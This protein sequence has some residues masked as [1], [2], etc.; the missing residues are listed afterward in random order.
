MAT[1]RDI[2]PCVLQMLREDWERAPHGQKGNVVK[3]WAKRTGLGYQALYKT[4]PCQRPQK[5]KSERKIEGIETAARIVAQYK[6]MAPDQRRQKVTEDAIALAVKNG[7]IEARFLDVSIGTF[8]RVIRELGLVPK[9]ARKSHFQADRPNQLHHIDA[10]SCDGFYIAAK[11]PDGDYLLKLYK[12]NYGDYKNKPTP[13]GLRPWYYGYVDDYSGCW[14]ARMVAALGESAGDNIDFLC[15]AWS[16]ES[17]MPWFGTPERLMGDKGPMIRDKS[18]REF[19]QRAADIVPEKGMPGNSAAHGK[20]EKVWDITWSRVT[21]PYFTGDWQ[22]FSITMSEFNRRY[23]I[24]QREWSSKR[25]HR[26]E[27]KVT[28]QQM[29]ERINLHGGAVV[30]PE[31]ALKTVVRC[32]TRNVDQCGCVSIDGI[33]Y[34]IKGL[35]S[36]KVKLYRGRFDDKLVAM[37]LADGRKYEVED[38]RPNSL[39]EFTAAPKTEHQKVRDEARELHGAQNLLHLVDSALEVGQQ[40]PR[41]VIKMQTRVKTRVVENPLNVNNYHT[42]DEALREFQGLCGFF[43][44]GEM[45]AEVAA[46]IIE[47]GLTKRFVAELAGEI[48][49]EQMQA[50]A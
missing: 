27:K 35:H 4:L 29:W 15:W 46:L 8:N 2:E 38:F 21:A 36:A 6:Y 30:F 41:K 45:R 48:Q 34:E 44:G 20:I 37:D 16:Q 17:G 19:L 32:Y 5:R 24:F 11:L 40:G 50:Q 43:L 7:D 23:Q 18:I 47:N 25:K 42:I 22:N 13:V 14:T 31:G 9:K 10:S 26:F 28:R 33:M 12:G 49:A 1:C 39:D 3:G